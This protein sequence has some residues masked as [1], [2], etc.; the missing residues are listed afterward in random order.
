MTSST[1]KVKS[2]FGISEKHTT[3]VLAILGFT[4][5]TIVTAH[6]NI[7][8]KPV[9]FTL[10]TVAV[11]LAGAFLGAKKGAY[12]QILYLLLGVAGLPVFAPTDPTLGIARLIGPT[13]GY[14]LAFPLAAFIAGFV[15]ERFKGNASALSG[16]VAANL[17]ILISGV[18]FLDL[19]YIKNLEQSYMLGAGIFSIWTL[20]KLALTFAI[21]KAFTK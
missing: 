6:I 5:L 9:P 14:L 1:L 19:F 16:M 2:M 11:V 13:G 18:L 10:Q 8:V 21:Y 12:S 20:A 3:T 7:P 17:S 4:A 15:I